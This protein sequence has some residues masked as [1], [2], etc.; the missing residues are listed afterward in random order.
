MDTN[1]ERHKKVCYELNALY[2]RKNRDHG[3][4][5][6][7]T[8]QKGGIKTAWLRIHD[9][10]R[11]FENIVLGKE[12]PKIASETV[13]DTLID[14]CNY[15]IMTVMELDAESQDEPKWTQEN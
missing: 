3:D 15:I 4:S 9:K 14:M 10:F 1:T 13:R 12:V 5:F 8:Y 11:R 6:H 2:D 7:E